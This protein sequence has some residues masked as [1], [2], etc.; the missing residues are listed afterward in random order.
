MDH[1][2]VELDGKLYE[3]KPL[4]IYMWMHIGAEDRD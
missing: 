4:D 2:N 1:A 3:K